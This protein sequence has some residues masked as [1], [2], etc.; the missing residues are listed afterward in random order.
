MCVC[1]RSLGSCTLSDRVDAVKDSLG[2]TQFSYILLRPKNLKMKLWKMKLLQQ[3]PLGKIAGIGIALEV[4][5]TI[6]DHF[7]ICEERALYKTR[8]RKTSKKRS[9]IAWCGRTGKG[10][11]GPLQNVWVFCK[12]NTIAT[13]LQAK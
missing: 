6:C 11:A 7:D 10:K 4:P 9:K 1:V 2:F 3:W 12:D 5:A 8:K 13:H